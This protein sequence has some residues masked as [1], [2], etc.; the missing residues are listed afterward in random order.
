M[1]IAKKS[2][3]LLLGVIMLFLLSISVAAESN[4]F[5]PDGVTGNG[6]IVQP[7][8]LNVNTTRLIYGNTWIYADMT[9]KSSMNLRIDIK[10]YK[11]GSL[12]HSDYTTAYGSFCG[13]DVDYVF[14]QGNKYK[15]EATYK[16]GT[17]SIPKS[18]SFTQ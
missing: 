11:N 2:T 18:I 9:T 5:V 6:I 16:A 10:V 15:I 8:Y 1:K 13:I 3:S 17:E 4:R 12:D 7:K 14:K